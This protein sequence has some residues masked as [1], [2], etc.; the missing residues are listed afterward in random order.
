M[1]K[2]RVLCQMIEI[3]RTESCPK[4]NQTL[5][6]KSSIPWTHCFLQENSTSCQKGPRPERFEEPRKQERR[7]AR[8]RKFMFLQ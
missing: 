7:N 3:I 2:F 4:Q 8:P 6:E 1:E 5:L